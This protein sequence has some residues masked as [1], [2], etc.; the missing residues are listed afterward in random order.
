MFDFLRSRPHPAVRP[1]G[2]LFA[3]TL[4]ASVLASP[5]HAQD[6]AATAQPVAFTDTVAAETKA[7]TGVVLSPDGAYLYA[8][9]IAGMLHRWQVDPETGDLSDMQTFE[10]PY[11]QDAKGGRGFIG[12]V[13]D[14][15]DPNVLWVT[16]NYPVERSGTLSRR[17]EFSGRVSRIRLGDGPEFTGEPEAY[18]QGLPRSC[19]DHLTNSL[20]FHEDPQ[21]A[22]GAPSLKL[23]LTQGS[24]SAMG[25][26]DPGWCFRPERLLTAGVLEIDPSLTPPEGGFDVSTEPLPLTEGRRFGY[27]WVLRN[28][29]WPSDDGDLK[30]GGIEIDEGPFQGSYL[31][32]AANGTATV[33]EGIDADSALEQ[34]FYDPFLPDAPVRIYATGVR[35]GYDL[36]W[37]SNGWLYVPSNGATGGGSIPDDPSLTGDQSRTKVN[38]TEDFLLKIERGAY[39]GHPNPLRDEFIAHGGNPT[40]AVDPNEV[41]DYD[42][43]TPPDPRYVASGSYPLGHHFSPN[44]VIEYTDDAFAGALRGAV[45]FVNYSAGNNLRAIMLDAAG[46]PTADFIIRNPEGEEIT[47]PDPLDLA[48]GRDGRIYVATLNRSNGASQIVKLDPVAMPGG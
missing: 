9:T 20:A 12:L 42:V 15:R 46:D 23:Y 5:L 1:S 27:S 28:I 31:H 37:H 16:D 2:R 40:E 19:G 6:A 26:A 7:V 34:A 17:P 24:N 45:I 13:F 10:H 25:A 3:A 8:G 4:L 44:G 11:F 32:F 39:M 47:Y 36:V 41:T 35:N 38:R 21:A 43:G 29:I 22:G 18:I 48:M 33:R 14:P 30:N